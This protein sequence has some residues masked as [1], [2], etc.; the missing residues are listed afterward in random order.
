MTI[1]FRDIEFADRTTA[2]AAV[3]VAYF[4]DASVAMLARYDD[5]GIVK[6]IV[7]T[8]DLPLP[9]DT[10]EDGNDIPLDCCFRVKDIERAVA[11]FRAQ[12]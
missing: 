4:Q 10:D 8:Y 3:V 12:I 11:K 7:E 2:S 5:M 1:I 9:G 6:E